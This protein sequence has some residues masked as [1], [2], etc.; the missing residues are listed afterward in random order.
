MVGDEVAMMCWENLEE[1]LE[2]SLTEKQV[3]KMK[4]LTM[5]SKKYDKAQEKH[6][7]FTLNTGN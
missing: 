6:V 3:D 2:E 4:D 5:M 7:D 1:F